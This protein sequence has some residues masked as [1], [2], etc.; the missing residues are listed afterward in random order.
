MKTPVK[1][2]YLC[3]VDDATGFVSSF[4]HLIQALE[5]EYPVKFEI[6]EHLDASDVDTM[7]SAMDDDD[8]LIFLIDYNLRGN[9]GQ[10]VDGDA[11][12]AQIR[13]HSEHPP[14]VFYSSNATQEEL[15]LLV[16]DFRRVVCVAREALNDVLIALASGSFDAE[17]L[18][19][20]ANGIESM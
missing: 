13:A 12:I 15:R 11:L 3:W 9:D 6:D 17:Y 19:V 5:S 1:K 2:I 10:G 18:N 20:G 4:S 7:A 8:A 16:N 14:I